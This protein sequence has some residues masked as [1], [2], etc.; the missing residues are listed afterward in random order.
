M[1]AQFV[2]SRV[3]ESGLSGD[4]ALNDVLWNAWN[5]IILGE[6]HICALQGIQEAVG[7]RHGFK[8]NLYS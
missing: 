8:L 6:P 7:R 2:I 4:T 3:E 1:P 5:E